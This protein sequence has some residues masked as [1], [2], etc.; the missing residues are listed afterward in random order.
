M[1][2]AGKGIIG[3]KLADPI[4]CLLGEK[5]E[6]MRLFELFQV[7]EFSLNPRALYLQGANAILYPLPLEKTAL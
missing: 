3:D 5:A 1:T 7:G 2:N 4:Y 6:I